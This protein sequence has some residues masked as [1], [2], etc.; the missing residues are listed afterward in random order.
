MD[1]TMQGF[2]RMLAGA[3]DCLTPV[4]KDRDL[5]A[6]E[7]RLL[8]EISNEKGVAIAGLAGRMPTTD[9]TDTTSRLAIAGLVETSADP[10]DPRQVVVRLTDRGRRVLNETET[11]LDERAASLLT[12][13]DEGRR[14]DVLGALASVQSLIDDE[15]DIHIEP[16]FRPGAIGEIVA[17][18]GRIFFA[19][20][21]LGT[22]FEASVAYSLAEFSTRSEQPGNG[23]WLA[24]RGQRVV[25]SVALD[26][27]DREGNIRWF[28]V[29]QDHRNLGISDRLITAALEHSRAFGL[30]RL[31]LTI[32]SGTPSIGETAV[33]NGFEPL[34]E[35]EQRTEHQIKYSL[36]LAPMRVDST[37][38]S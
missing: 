29:D 4:F 34:A 6:S 1:D 17:L 11:E 2:A 24:L 37:T 3:M 12:N 36:E 8:F 14:R 20:A 10:L 21:A 5:S 16:G 28:I 38:L 9:V 15:A 7:A 31:S 23:I 33:R 32:K 35:A 22:A 18:H 13:L 26:T 19:K 25:G 27:E 30:Q